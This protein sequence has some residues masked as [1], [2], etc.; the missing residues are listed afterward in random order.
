MSCKGRIPVVI[1]TSTSSAGT[2]YYMP[3]SSQ[4]GGTKPEG[5]NKGSTERAPSYTGKGGLE[6]ILR[7]AEDAHIRRLALVGGPSYV[8]PSIE[9]PPN[10]NEDEAASS[11]YVSSPS[12]PDGSHDRGQSTSF[13]PRSSAARAESPNTVVEHLIEDAEILNEMEEDC[14]ALL[15]ATTSSHP[16]FFNNDPR[17]FVDSNPS[18]RPHIRRIVRSDT[19]ATVA[20]HD[21]S[22]LPFPSSAVSL[23]ESAGSMVMTSPQMTSP[24]PNLPIDDA[25]L[26]PD[27]LDTS[28]MP[29]ITDHTGV[30]FHLMS[31]PPSLTVP[32]SL[33]LRSLDLDYLVYA[34]G[35]Q[36][37]FDFEESPE[38]DKLMD[39]F[40]N[41]DEV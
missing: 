14:A 36:L 13:P 12:R 7:K 25:S 21:H 26:L 20:E 41:S 8:V 17:H 23:P 2:S 18:L 27:S 9:V 24:D 1:A 19:R 22:L 39:E 29:E 5:S 32:G 30:D 35:G 38:N 11:R 33:S 15:H 4:A 6:E 10:V 31:G 16:C 37:D 3:K 40:V 28:T 34:P